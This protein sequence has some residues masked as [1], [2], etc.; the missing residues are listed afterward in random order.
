MCGRTPTLTPTLR[1]LHVTTA[2]GRALKGLLVHLRTHPGMAEPTWIV[3]LAPA[4]HI[5]PLVLNPMDPAC[6]LCAVIPVR[7]EAEHIE[8]TLTAF[9]RQEDALGTELDPRL[10]EVIV[11][12]NNCVDD[13]AN[14]ARRFA[15]RHPH[16]R[17]HVVERDLPAL[18]AHVGAARRILADEAYRRLSSLPSQSGVIAMTDGDS[19]VSDTWVA[20]TLQEID[21]G[22]DVVGGRIVVDHD[23]LVSLP[24]ST[25]RAHLNDV[26][27]R[28][29]A[30]SLESRI[31]PIPYDPWPRH[32]Q[33][34]GPS[35][36]M[37]AD[38]YRRSGGIPIQPWLE[39]VALIRALQAIDARIRHSPSVRVTTSGRLAGRTTFGY[40]V[41]LGMW[42]EMAAAR[43]PVMVE[44]AGAIAARATA[45]RSLRHLWTERQTHARDERSLPQIAA[46]LCVPPGWLAMQAYER[47]FF[48]ALEQ[49]IAERQ[50][51]DGSWHARWPLVPIQQAIGELRVML[52]GS[53]FDL[54]HVDQI[55]RMP[56]AGDVTQ[57]FRHERHEGIVDIVT[58]QRR[59]IDLG[60]VMDEDDAAAWN[61][62]LHDLIPREAQVSD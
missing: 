62:M 5:E 59:V 21:N 34:F 19:I 35:I 61:D 25:R 9:S 33:H 48:G 30:T 31:D 55:A 27:Y 39:D 28:W 15:D 17:L 52:S 3:P 14:V 22:A 37:T 44:T 8:R 6:R 47:R 7:D 12:A 1:A 40:A 46:R 50:L 57:D 18:H 60:R 24:I 26:M 45:L 51:A 53:S 10:F 58:A 23:D 11:L 20:A 42:A 36:A 13:S 4:H 16:L 43:H 2:I 32:F 49:T 54:E 41:Q 56:L 29:L 38:A